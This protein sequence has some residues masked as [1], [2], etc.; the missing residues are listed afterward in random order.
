MTAFVE[1]GFPL[2]IWLDA[3]DPSC[4]FL[5]VVHR[6]RDDRE[7]GRIVRDRIRLVSTV[8]TYGG[9][10]WWFVCPP[11]HFQAVFA[12]RRLAFLEPAGL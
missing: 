6:T 11:A 4:S 10:R 9:R 1:P 7:G 2:T 3:S 12:R 8:P 5:E